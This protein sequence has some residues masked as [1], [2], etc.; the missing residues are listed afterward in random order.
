MALPPKS[1]AD[2]EPL[3]CPATQETA[4]TTVFAAA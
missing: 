2:C 4:P 1:L 3:A